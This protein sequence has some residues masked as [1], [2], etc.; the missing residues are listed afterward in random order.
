MSGSLAAGSDLTLTHTDIADALV[1]STFGTS[2]AVLMIA[3]LPDITTQA[4]A[5]VIDALLDNG[6]GNAAGIVRWVDTTDPITAGVGQVKLMLMG[7][8]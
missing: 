8:Q 6:N 1:D 7:A 5:N 3:T 4:Q 2:T